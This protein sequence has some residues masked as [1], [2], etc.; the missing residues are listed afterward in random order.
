[1]IIVK[2]SSGKYLLSAGWDRRVCIWDLEKLRLFD[3][4]RNK[5]VNSF[6]EVELASDGNIL[7]MCYCE[8]YD[9][10]AY[11]STDSMCYVRKFGVCGSEMVLVSTLQ[12]HLSDVNCIRWHE[13]RDVWVTGGEDNSIRIWVILILFLPTIF[14]LYCK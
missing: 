6:D 14:T 11:A 2:D 1:M 7:D 8:K 9:W 3:L 10:F 13:P 5:N 12:G 4:F